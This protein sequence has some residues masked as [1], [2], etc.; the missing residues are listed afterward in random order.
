MTDSSW[1]GAAMGLRVQ[2]NKVGGTLNTIGHHGTGG[3][4]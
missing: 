1:G 2:I 3:K 4:E